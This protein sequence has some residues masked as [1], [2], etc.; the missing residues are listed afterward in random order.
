MNEKA[1]LALL[2][3]LHL[4]L[5]I[6]F[7]ARMAIGNAPDEPAHAHYV[8][9]L[10]KTGRPP[11]WNWP[12]EPLSY[13]AVQSPLYYAA[14]AAWALPVRGLPPVF[15]VRWIRAFSTLLHLLALL[16]IWRLACGFAGAGMA[17]ASTAVVA[18]LP[19]FLFIGA[20]VGNDS[21]ANLCGAL[22][23]MVWM[24]HVR[25]GPG[26][27][28][29]AAALGA[30]AGLGLLAK[31]TLA[32]P[33][34]C[35]MAERAWTWRRD[36]S[37]RRNGG[38]LL[39]AALPF[40][41]LIFGRNLLLGGGLWGIAP[42]AAYDPGGFGLSRLHVWL[43]IFFESFWGKFGWMTQ[44]LPGWT[45]LVL[46]AVSV[47][48]LAGLI[49]GRRRLLQGER[50]LLLLVFC[51][52]LAQNFYY[53]FVLACQPQARFS[54]ITLGAWAPLFCAGLAFWFEPLQQGANRAL[55]WIGLTLLLGLDLLA[56]RFL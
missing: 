31:A 36:A 48:S 33:I 6:A 20:Q 10:L 53:G 45:Y 21:L 52:A 15:Q 19:M 25:R 18:L 47:L 32:A 9:T 50:A 55:A 43:R 17:L 30:V 40:W 26:G 2:L 49:A 13:E 34:L 11:V 24:A 12:R 44:P 39:L 5:G 3:G 23:L 7:N 14:A 51:A 8:E 27:P 41:A 1:A 4:A 42:N 16:C 38:T 54:F 46:L 56:L 29:D 35:V 37:L 22:L 28:A